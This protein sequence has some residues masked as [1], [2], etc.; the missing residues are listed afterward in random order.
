[1]NQLEAAFLAT[2]NNNSGF[3]PFNIDFIP[4]AQANGSD[5]LVEGMNS[6]MFIAEFG[7]KEGEMAEETAISF[8]STNS[9]M[10]T[11]FLRK[12]REKSELFK[13]ALRGYGYYHKDST[14]NA[15]MCLE[16]AVTYFS[17]AIGSPSIVS[18][19]SILCMAM[20]HMSNQY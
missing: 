19:I 9:F 4:T 8:L 10:S 5:L 12:L 7:E 17:D 11:E 16:K 1:M 15:K 18:V 20:L 6:N 14:E 2:Q 13:Y 3:V